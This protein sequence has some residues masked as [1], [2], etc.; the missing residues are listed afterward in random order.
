MQPVKHKNSS[1]FLHAQ[2]AFEEHRISQ[3]K[4]YATILGMINDNLLAGKIIVDTDMLT[5][6]T[7]TQ[8]AKDGF[9]VSFPEYPKRMDSNSISGCKQV[10]F[11]WQQSKD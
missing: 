3:L 11:E 4:G 5:Q 10:A 6:D 8:L 1:F 2:R 9:S 7:V